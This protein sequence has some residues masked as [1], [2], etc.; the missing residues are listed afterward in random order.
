MSYNTEYFM[1]VVEPC[2]G[3]GHI[4]PGLY[5]DR[6]AEPVK[7]WSRTNGC[8]MRTH[9]RTTQVASE[10]TVNPLKAAKRSVTKIG[11]V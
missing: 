6:Y 9:R 8:A 4:T 3:C 2:T 1:M 11:G 7:Q 5:C 10:K